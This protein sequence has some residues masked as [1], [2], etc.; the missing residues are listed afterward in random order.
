SPAISNYSYG[1]Y[2]FQS[3]DGV[4]RNITAYNNSAYGIILSVTDNHQLLDVVSFNNSD[5][6]LFY[7]TSDYGFVNNSQFYNNSGS[8]IRVSSSTQT[9]FSFIDSYNNSEN[10][11]VLDGLSNNIR[12]ENSSFFMNDWNGVHF[13]SGASDNYLYN[14]TAYNNSIDGFRIML[15]TTTG[16]TI[17]L[18]ESH[19]NR[20]GVYYQNPGTINSV[21][22]LTLYDNLAEF[23]A[24]SNG[25]VFT[26]DARNLTFTNPTGSL[27][28]YTVLDVQD[29]VSA[30]EAYGI[31]WI[32]NQ[33]SPP[34]E[35]ISFENKYVRIGNVSANPVSI[36]ELVWHWSAGEEGGYIPSQFNL[37]RYNVSE[38]WSLV[39]ETPDTGARTLSTYD[40][41]PASSDYG[42]LQYV[43]NVSIL[44]LNQTPLPPSEGG[45]VEFN[46]TI[47]N[48]G[49]VT[50]DTVQVI[51]ELPAGLT[52]ANAAPAPDVSADPA[53]TWNNVGPLPPG[54][55][56]IIYVNATVDAGVATPGNR[57]VNVT[58]YVNATFDS[59]LTSPGF[60]EEYENATV[61]FANLTITKTDVSSYPPVPG[62]TVEYQIDVENTGNVTLS[63]I[64]IDDAL[65]APFNYSNAD[66][67]PDSTGSHW[68]TW[69]NVGPLA[70]GATTTIY[71]NAT[72]N[73]SAP[74]GAQLNTAAGEGA[75]V[76]GDNVTGTDDATTTVVYP[77]ISVTKTNPPTA[78]IGD[79]VTYTIEV[80]NTGPVNLTVSVNDTIPAGLQ[81][82]NASP[83]NTSSS[84]NTVYWDD[85]FVDLT[86]GSSEQIEY[87]A[88]VL[89]N[90]VHIN[91]VWAVGEPAVGEDVTDDTR[92]RISVGQ[93]EDDD[94]GKKLDEMYIVVSTPRLVY[95]EVTLTVMEEDS[96]PISNAEVK[97]KTDAPGY[98]YW[99]HPGET[100]SDG[101]VTFV[102]DYAAPYY[103]TAEKSGYYDSHDEFSVSEPKGECTVNQDCYDMY[104]DCFFCNQVDHMCSLK[105]GAE[106]G[107]DE[108][109]QGYTPEKVDKETTG[110][111]SEDEY[112]DGGPTI[113]DKTEYT[114][115]E[116]TNAD[117][118]LDKENY[119]CIDCQCTPVECLTDDDCEEG[120]ECI[121]YE[122][123]GEPE[124][125]GCTSD[126]DCASDEYCN[127]DTGECEQVECPCGQIINHECSPYECCSDPTC[128]EIYGDNYYCNLN[129][130]ECEPVEEDEEEEEG[131][132]PMDVDVPGEVSVGQP[133]HISVTSGGEPVGDAEVTVVIQGTPYG[134]GKTGPSGNITFIPEEEGDYTVVVSKPGFDTGE[135]DFKATSEPT[136]WDTIIRGAWI[137]LF[138]LILVA[139]IYV[140]WTRKK[141]RRP[142]E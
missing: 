114:D 28:N 50:L 14:C 61:Y 13:S 10:G 12:A 47:N 100:N 113:E 18:G 57:I 90:G 134:A 83:A 136:L 52:Y 107:F 120:Q 128:L 96:T 25:D 6:G 119:A 92:S 30:N 91:E 127:P 86:P 87:N 45:M 80:T 125:E 2:Y 37:V 65:P 5:H 129:I 104:N 8:G 123:V 115:G 54:A 112:T 62:A 140:L 64:R 101:E 42:I 74:E 59:N 67:L 103:A 31:L 108:D 35:A 102:P 97:I 55:S 9:N 27:D 40:L 38:G 24:Y 85:I 135:K 106:C 116:A 33:T 34:E 63:Q 126:S 71:L 26:V 84:G 94:G 4:I 122:C 7:A 3:D 78:N 82:L 41:D 111:P 23:I 51:D 73:E 58:N 56:T 142:K 49:N 69:D 137:L 79:N 19:G 139:V 48:T 32:L 68:A 39:N 75:P 17:Y 70:P 117:E 99:Y 110:G 138:L 53:Y 81:F 141:K 133:V 77:S 89:A 76:N 60:S 72:I 66:P 15:S 1:A 118:I 121:D 109:C 20:F 95:Q 29:D 22:N 130:H 46:I 21:Y 36:D 131:D 132:Q 43:A 98:T 11:I 44:K 124:E 16:N 93:E 88:S 105:K